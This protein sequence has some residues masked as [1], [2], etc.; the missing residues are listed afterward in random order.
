[1]IQ[2][3]QAE[4]GFLAVVVF[5]FLR[6]RAAS[7][8]WHTIEIYLFAVSAVVPFEVGERTGDLA[9]TQLGGVRSPESRGEESITRSCVTYAAVRSPFVKELQHVL[10]LVH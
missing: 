8:R 2:V 4:N 1:M 5:V 9:P 7:P 3:G 6:I 10:G